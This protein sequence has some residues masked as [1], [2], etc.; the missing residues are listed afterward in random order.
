[1][2]YKTISSVSSPACAR[3]LASDF[4]DSLA[5]N[6]LLLSFLCGEDADTPC[7]V[8][9]NVY[10]EKYLNE[11]DMQALQ[12]QAR[13]LVQQ[14]TSPQAWHAG[15][16]GKLLRFC[17]QRTLD[18]VR[19][20]WEQYDASVSARAT[21]FYQ[22]HFKSAMKKSD[23][24][25][26]KA[27]GPGSTVYTAARSAAPV[28]LPMAHDLQ[29]T[30]LNM[31]EQDVAGVVDAPARYPNPTFATALSDSVTLAFPSNPLLS[32]HL[33]TAGLDLAEL[34]PL[35]LDT[36][37]E[38]GAPHSK[39]VR[40]AKLQFSEWTN[41]FKRLSSNLVIRYI[42]ADCFAFCQTLQGSLGTGQTTANFYRRQLDMRPLVLSEAAYG[43]VGMAPRQFDVIDTSNLSDHSGILNILVSAGP[44]LRDK[45]WS[46]LY[47]EVMARG[48]VADKEKLE[49]LLCGHTKALSLLLG[50]APIEYWTNASAVSYVD[51]L[52]VAIGERAEN[53]DY[54]QK[55]QYRL[56][57]KPDS[58][59]SG[60]TPA[61]LTVDPHTLASL[62]LRVYLE[63]FGG[64]NPSFLASAMGEPSKVASFAY[65][66]YHRGS[67]VALVKA[68]CCNVNTDAREVGRQLMQM[69]K[70]DKTLVF[71]GNYAQGLALALSRAGIYSEP[72][73]TRE[74]RRD[75]SRGMFCKWDEIPEAIAVTLV[76]PPSRWKPI[77][78]EAVDC[79]IGL[80]LEGHL[81]KVGSWHNM[82]AD[83]QVTFGTLTTS[84]LRDG[85]DYAVSVQEDVRGCLGDSPIVVS[86][87]A[88]AAAVQIDMR[89][90]QVALCLQNT[91][92]NVT[93]FAA[94]LGTPMAIFETG[95]GD[96]NHV[97][98][99]KHTPGQQGF[100]V[101]GSLSRQ[102]ASFSGRSADVTLTPEIEES[103]GK[104]AA[105]TG[106][107][108]IT[109]DEGK[110]YLQD[111]LPIALQQ[112]SPFTIDVV[113]GERA[114]VQTITYRVPV[115]QE[116]SRSR[117]ARK[118]GYVEVIAKLAEPGVSGILEEYIFPT[119]TTDLSVSP[120][121]VVPATLNIPHLSLDTLPIIDVAEK[122]SIRFLDSLAS[123]TFSDRERHLREEVLASAT[124]TGLAPSVRLNFKETLL[125][126][127][128]VSSGLQ[129]GQTGLFAL[130]LAETGIHMLLFVSALR[131][132]GANAS[133]VLD[134]A[135]IPV[136]T[137]MLKDADFEAFL[138][139]LRTLECCTITVDAAELALMKKVLPA[140]AERCRTWSHAE[141]CE[142]SVQGRAPLSLDHGAQVLCSCGQ[143]KLPD[144][145][146]GVPDWEASARRFAT[147]IAISPTFAVPFVEDVVYSEFAK[148]IREH[149]ETAGKKPEACRNC[150][151]TRAA[152]GG[153]L[154]KCMRCL[155][156]KYCSAECQKKDWKKHRMECKEAAVY[157]MDLD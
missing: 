15:P 9:W 13:K 1:M 70:D 50:L 22:G 114:L 110:R 16:Y 155:E 73:L 78:R 87:Y 103:T 129:G 148:S 46:T 141:G 25:K 117:V 139:L 58:S 27:Y 86:F 132:D 57:W 127:L 12:R 98:I 3:G 135:V 94:K 52:L 152:D 47:A 105:I 26:G 128:M 59:L 144:G 51:E 72:W 39:F 76:V 133:V 33:A 104:I 154:K 101:V 38:E 82:Y 67:F 123:F 149:P 90:S 64:E 97:H 83:V 107:A 108:N 28:Y 119:V 19:A 31:W 91:M 37:A 74:I 55:T 2:I 24:H 85:D 8:L 23:E 126:I 116:N 112:T 53:P 63:M 115:T 40:A 4:T 153:A 81:R 17:D 77:F 84:G 151:R 145:F 6:V 45:P 42:A 156:V 75:P 14:S 147:R 20:V 21:S 124:Q 80:T 113:F 95:L 146:V 18:C 44:L 88:A 130:S 96:G 10:Y 120:G 56:A 150:G 7:E 41:A 99:T 49:A 118:S 93:V 157:G 35:R 121:N 60:T 65:P 136:T 79:G 138:L 69:I 66:P 109:S 111:K 32:F 36:S 89:T 142:Y 125:T 143:G 54:G 68:V 11:S 30:M 122:K 140:L 61:A 71:D 48:T 106:R 134:A 5:R 29:H 102:P 100:P 43:E 137:A 62:L 131:L 92:Q 34:S